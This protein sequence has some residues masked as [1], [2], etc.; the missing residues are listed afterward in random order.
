MY[1]NSDNF[2]LHI[3]QIG[4]SVQNKSNVLEFFYT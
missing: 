3:G 1:L 4:I 2:Y